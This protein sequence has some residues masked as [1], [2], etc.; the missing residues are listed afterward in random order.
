M[1]NKKTELI[2]N[3][4]II[5]LGK[6]STQFLTFLLLPVYTSKISSTEYGNIDLIISYSTFL[7]PIITIQQEFAVFRF[8]ID[9][10][11]D[12]R[13]VAGIISTGVFNIL[14]LLLPFSIIA[15]PILFLLKIKF[16]EWIILNILATA[17]LSFFL[18]V[19]RGVGES[20]KY[21]VTS[22]L[23]GMINVGLNLFFIFGLNLGGEAILIASVISSIA[24]VCYLLGS[25]RLTDKIAKTFV[26]KDIK[27]MLIQYSLPVMLNGVAWWVVNASD[28]TIMAYFVSL[29]AVGVYAAANTFAS[30]VNGLFYIFNMSWSESASMHLKS[31]DAEGYFSD[32]F[33]SMVKIFTFICSALIF[34]LPIAFKLLIKQD[35]RESYN[36]IPLLVLGAL[37]CGIANYYS[38][39]YSALLV[40]QKIMKTTL[41][42]GIVNVL[43]DLVLVHFIGVY[44]AI[45]ST[46][47]AF[48][49]MLV[50]RHLDIIKLIKITVS[51]LAVL[52]FVTSFLSASIFFYVENIWVKVA[53]AIIFLIASSIMAKDLA[54]MS[55]K[56]IKE[57][58]K[59]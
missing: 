22:I 34:A 4:L 42:A 20:L 56:I 13:K 9:A 8:L 19:S 57:K 6:M 35:Y 55:L 10:R 16:A 52:Y 51:P 25:L 30:V 29:S 59:R 50:M 15:T 3:T 24:G 28:R 53:M 23:T 14:K 26:K 44:A 18:Q 5:A 49:I 41:I 45:I 58:T 46:I 21:S 43:I 33:N 32:V 48:S 2:K 40:P 1:K 38:C 31:K 54:I 11:G 12:D 39:I 27:K 17:T 37:I 7:I 36:Y 47:I